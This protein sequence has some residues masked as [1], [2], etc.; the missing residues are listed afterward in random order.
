MKSAAAVFTFFPFG[1]SG[2][3]SEGQRLKGVPPLDTRDTIRT[4]ATC[5]SL[6]KNGVFKP[7]G[8]SSIK[9]KW[10]TEYQSNASG[11]DEVLWVL[12]VNGKN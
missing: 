7:Q 2:R 10:N 11:D 5:L 9:Q 4:T 1:R 12:F 8:Q 6:V 3:D